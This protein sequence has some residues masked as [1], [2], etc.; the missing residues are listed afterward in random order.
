M[1]KLA[2]AIISLLILPITVIG[3]EISV[4]LEADIS[5]KHDVE[6]TRTAPG[7]LT[8][9]TT[10]ADPFFLF[11]PLP[12]DLGDDSWVLSFDY[13]ST[14]AI[15]A[16]Q[17]FF[18]PISS[19]RA[20][21]I[22]S[23]DH[24]SEWKEFS[25]VLKNDARRFNWGKAGDVMRIDLGTWGGATIKVR[26]LGLRAMTD[27]EEAFQKQV[28]AKEEEKIQRGK[29]L[30]AYLSTDYPGKV[31]KVKV[32]D[33]KVKI[34]GKR[35][36]GKD[37][38]L[39]EITPWEDIDEKGLSD[40]LIPLRGRR[41]GKSVERKVKREG[42]IYDRSL[43][44]WAI[45]QKGEEGKI[46]LR[47]HAR[48]ADAIQPVRS[49]T[50][51]KLT[52]KKGLGGYSIHRFKT[53]L[54]SLDIRSVTINIHLNSLL[55]ASQR[56]KTFA[57]EYGGITYWFDSTR[58]DYL[59]RVL[60]YCT[61]RG[62]IT[63]A[64][65]LIDLK[66]ADPALTPVFRH[67]DCDG[68]FYSMPNMTTAEGFNAYAAVLDFLADRYSSGEHG[69]I[70]NWIIHNEVDYGVDWT[71]M[72]KQPYEVYM[73][74]YEKSM[75]LNY[76]LADRY[77]QQTWV[78]GSYTHNW[79]VSENENGFCVRQMLDDHVR[80]GNA[81]G[82]FRWGVAQHPYPQDLTA[83]EFWE[84]D[85]E[86]TYS[87]DSKYI[88][89]KNLE[90]IDAWIWMPEHLY[91]GKTKRLLFLS[92]NGTN[93]RNYSEEELTKQAAGACWAWK[94][95]VALPG[96]D[97][98]QW[99][100]W[101]DN[102]GEFGLKIGL[103]RYHDDETIPGGIK[104]AWR[105]WQAAGTDKEDEVF[106]PYLKVMGLNDWSEIFHELEPSV[107][108][109][110]EDYREGSW[111]AFRKGFDIDGDPSTATLDI[112]ADTKY[113]LWVNGQLF[114]R[115][116]NL[117]R[118]PTPKDG[119][120][121]H[122]ESVPG[123]VKGHN[124]VA[125]LVNFH[126]RKSVNHITSPTAGLWFDLRGN[127]WRVISDSSWKAIRHPA[128]YIPEG[129]CPNL[130]LSE[131]NIGFDG[132]KQIDF[133]R[134]GFDDSS[135][136]NAKAL[137]IDDAGWGKQVQ[138]PIPQWKDYGLKDY[139]S[140]KMEGRELICTLPYDCQVT[141]YIKVK[142]PEGKIID[143]YTDLYGM[144]VIEGVEPLDDPNYNPYAG[145][146][147]FVDEETK[148]NGRWDSSHDP[149]RNRTISET[150]AM[151]PEE[152]GKRF[153]SFPLLCT[154]G[155]Y[156]TRE[157]VQEHETPG[158][159]N[160]M[161]VH[162]SIPE[163]VEVLE[164]KYRE[165]GYNTTF[166]GSFECDDPFLNTLW[167]R[168]ARTLYVNMRDNFFD[169]PHRER[170]QWIGDAANEAIQT[171]YAFDPSA[172]DLVA[173]CIRE[174]AGFQEGNG[175]MYGPTPGYN[176]GE[177]VTQT[178]A[179]LSC[180]VPE[181][182]MYTGDISPL[183]DVYGAFKKY[184]PLW[185]IGPDGLVQ[186]R[187]SVGTPIANWGDWGENKD[188]HLLYNAWVS[189]LLGTA[190]KYAS[191]MGDAETAA[192]A[193]E[194]REALVKTINNR[195]WKG[196]YYLSD[197]HKGCPDDRG[198]A[199]AVLGGVASPSQFD[200]LRP[201]FKEHYHASPYMEYY[202]LRALCE[203]GFCQDALDRMRTR[204]S[205]M[206]SSDYSTLWELFGDGTGKTDSYNHAWSGG[207]L[208]ILSRYVAGIYPTEPGFSKFAIE[209]HLCDLHNVK[210]TVSTVKGEIKVE[211]NKTDGKVEYSVTVPD[212]T[213]GELILG[214]ETIT[215][216]PGTQKIER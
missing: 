19:T 24:T 114:V 62:V 65:T 201:F 160:G 89:F 215:L 27:E 26:N 168:A 159:M 94:K 190:E 3:R 32:S 198:Q 157:G 214:D 58:V 84:N 112:E 71:N 155:Q 129:G 54:D 205:E 206:I 87:I 34:R 118:G 22:S 110:G 185:K 208:V 12:K 141:P 135:W 172:F 85:V 175:S 101:Q 79:N 11:K 123:L 8:I 187:Q 184:L 180:A 152:I 181:Y 90:V 73:D 4:P 164:V 182:Y 216:S 213:E 149:N 167:E 20:I 151:T 97:A 60:S 128:F 165:S 9:K 179:F 124:E 174:L 202:V 111:Y 209:P 116:G 197:E 68:G 134:K 132:R 143:I 77:D 40:E 113:W 191:W 7:E 72:G 126:G 106:A 2:F 142:A 210:A 189:V 105:V 147:T 99:H 200:A 119:Y 46:E 131:S 109:T 153:M 6:I 176:F 16:M 35:P 91:Q 81:E 212:G 162:Y 96:I 13:T 23:L 86:T 148:K 146:E 140:T 186:E 66:S 78:L 154:R 18:A 52:G 56:P 49:A 42:I 133:F 29:A 117:K 92:E 41:F 75:R 199:V 178:T 98:L 173:K 43:S 17:L 108:C 39:S 144:P 45:V 76:N 82:D 115:E 183:K 107:I 163:G 195:Y 74:A 80:Y 95:L 188:M 51:M 170:G 130:R 14:Q 204:Y 100:A 53:D 102:R 171:Y 70:N 1:K 93:S 161:T 194:T 28:E 169:C 88:T 59:D 55:Y 177:L 83:P 103:R 38:Y 47:S 30:A 193:R 37:F 67:P 63:S 127:G 31:V 122:F 150:L 139:V 57:R 48:Y 104:P 10:G 15:N 50:P 120:Y 5:T 138:R 121:D 44:R 36:A 25:V 125:V 156:I 69:R 203:M 211:I 158:W 64:I 33:G 61:E 145:V 207:P 166:A 136:P 21:N 192:A 137:S 196:N